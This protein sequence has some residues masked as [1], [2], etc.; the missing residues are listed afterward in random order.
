M[1]F[2]IAPFNT[3]EHLHLHVQGV[4]YASL[5]RAAKYFIASGYGFYTKGFSWFVEL[6]QAIDIL[7]R[8]KAINIMPC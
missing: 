5:R 3:V 8:G 6:D 1:G 2:H 4:P 7:G